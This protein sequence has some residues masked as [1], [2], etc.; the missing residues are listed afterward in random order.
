MII[1]TLFYRS[2]FISVNKQYL[3]VHESVMGHLLLIFLYQLLL[4][5]FAFQATLLLD[6]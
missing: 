3:H 6:I 2:D 1:L 5:N 4:V